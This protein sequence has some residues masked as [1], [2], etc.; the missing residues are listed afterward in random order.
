MISD[1]INT[2]NTVADITRDLIYLDGGNVTV[3]TATETKVTLRLV[4]EGSNCKECVMPGDF[5]SQIVL[6]AAQAQLPSLETV[7]IEDPR[8]TND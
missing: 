1:N 8:E 2:G 4:L 3:I 7:H 5:L 6:S